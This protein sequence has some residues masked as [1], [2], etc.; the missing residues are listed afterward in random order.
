MSTSEEQIKELNDNATADEI[1]RLKALE[2][3]AGGIKKALDLQIQ[4]NQQSEQI[5]IKVSAL[6]NELLALNA[7]TTYVATMIKDIVDNRNQQQQ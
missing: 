7:R 3:Q 1:E 5:F 2:A 4:R 6:M